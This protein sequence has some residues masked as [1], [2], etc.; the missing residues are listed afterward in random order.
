MNA[1]RVL[2]L[3]MALPGSVSGAQ[4]NYGYGRMGDYLGD[5]SA[6]YMPALF[7]GNAKYDGRFTFARIAYRGTGMGVGWRHDY[8]RAESHFMRIIRQITT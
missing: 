1:I 8:P 2:G 4:R 7:H 6:I 3:A 5:Q